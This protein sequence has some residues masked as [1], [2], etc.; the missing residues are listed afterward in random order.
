MNKIKLILQK[1]SGN[2]VKMI[3]KIRI[4]FPEKEEGKQDQINQL[5]LGDDNFF[6]LVVLYKTNHT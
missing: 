3:K 5:D 2:N 6:V 4:M 1:G